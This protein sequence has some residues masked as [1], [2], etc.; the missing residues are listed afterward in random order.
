MRLELQ[1]PLANGGRSRYLGE[2]RLM[3][4]FFLVVLLGLIPA[5]IAQS[6]GR[7]FLTWWIYGALLFII[8][9]PHAL[10]LAQ[11]ETY[12]KRKCPYCAE[13]IKAE[14]RVCR[15]C[16]RDVPSLKKIY[17]PRL[18]DDQ[19][20]HAAKI[21][22]EVGGMDW[23]VAKNCVAF[24]PGAV[25]QMTDSEMAER[26]RSALDEAGLKPDLREV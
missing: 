12:G 7:S 10:L 1:K 22:S 20:Y 23:A 6:K 11:E 26:I 3:E 8:A 5:M 24:T 21:L 2:Q 17:V 25:C 13:I 18:D 16:G 19:K 9:L 14:A 15:F 4:I